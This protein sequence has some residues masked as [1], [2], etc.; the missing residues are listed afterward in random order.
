MRSKPSFTINF[1]VAHKL[2]AYPLIRHFSLEEFIQKPYRVFR[3]DNGI[4]LVICGQGSSNASEAVRYLSEIIDGT[5]NFKQGWINVGIAGHKTLDLGFCFLANKILSKK[6]G[7][8]YYPSMSAGTKNTKGLIT[9][10]RPEKLYAEDAAYDMEASGFF[11][12]AVLCSELELIYVIKVISDNKANSMDN[13]TK[14]LVD[15]LMLRTLTFI[16]LVVCELKSRLALLNQALVLEHNCLNMV[17]SIHFSVY[18][19]NQFRKIC[20]QFDAMGR[21]EELSLILHC[22]I[23]PADQ[24]LQK[25]SDEL[26]RRVQ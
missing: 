12:A 16:D 17:K 6:T 4:R 15:D 18:Q 21:K 19:R 11:K 1:V 20:Q 13:I 26:T 25:L 3:N 9:V 10:D 22:N 2:E 7:E 14:D 24:L 5:P 8:V 23:A